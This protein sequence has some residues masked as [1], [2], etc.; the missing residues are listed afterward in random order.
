MTEL[1][2]RLDDPTLGGSALVGHL[3]RSN[4]RGRDAI[5]PFDLDHQLI[6]GPGRQY[7]RAGAARFSPALQDAST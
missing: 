1:D 2:V 6:L 4:H 7:P 3:E 5:A